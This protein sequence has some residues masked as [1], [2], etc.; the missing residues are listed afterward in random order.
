VLHGNPEKILKFNSSLAIFRH[1]SN[2]ISSKRRKRRSTLENESK[3][4]GPNDKLKLFWC[5][6]LQ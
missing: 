6:F 1:E 4:I 3:G 2:V 5:V